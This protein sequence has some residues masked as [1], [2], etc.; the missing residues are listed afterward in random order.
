MADRFDRQLVMFRQGDILLVAVPEAP[1]GTRVRP[2]HGRLILAEGEVTGHHHSVACEAGELIEA[3][4]AEGVPQVFL[5]LF[6]TTTLDHQEH[7]S[8]TLPPGD[9]RIGRQREYQP[10][11]LPRQV[12]D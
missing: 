10:G 6:E 7:S 8:I 4:V 11:E 2:K 9:Y 1:E 5:R 12:A 3:G